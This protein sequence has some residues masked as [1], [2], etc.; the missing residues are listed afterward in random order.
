VHQFLPTFEP[1]AIGQ[2]ALMVQAALREAG[3][4]S[5]IFA[6]YIRPPFEGR[7]HVHTDYGRRIAAGNDDALMYHMALGSNVADWLKDR[8]ETLI[9]RHHNITPVEYYSPWPDA[10]T[11]GMAWGR[12][13]LRELAGRVSIGCGVSEF[14]RRE[15]EALHYKR[16]EVTPLLLDFRQF[17]HEVDEQVDER[18]HNEAS[19]INWIFVGWIAPHKCQHDIIRAFALYRRLYDQNARLYLIGRVGLESYW[20]ACQKLIAKLGLTDAVVAPGRVTDG[21]LGAYYRNADV[22]VSLSE[23]EGVGI[24]LLEGMHHQLPIV[25]Y[26][27]AAI[28]ETVGD[29]GVLLPRKRPAH[30][31]AAVHRVT[32]DLVLRKQLTERASRRL[33][34][35]DHDNAKH[36]LLATLR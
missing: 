35:F 13:Q 26:A 1:G 34:L 11:Y 21:E 36:K 20:I 17:D 10:N 5:E 8:K 9:L 4:E 31:A 28:P 3:Y 23:H 15:L 25:A 32:A 22:F 29:A 2:D 27:A 24:P 7:A 16:T 6:E 18:L 30:V 14:N 19:G 12:H 33:A